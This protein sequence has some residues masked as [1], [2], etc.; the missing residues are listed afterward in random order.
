MPEQ[1][2]LPIFPTLSCPAENACMR[3][4]IFLVLIKRISFSFYLSVPTST[5]QLIH[6]GLTVPQPYDLGF[7]TRFCYLRSKLFLNRYTTYLRTIAVRERF[8]L[9]WIMCVSYARDYAI[10]LILRFSFSSN[11]TPLFGGQRF[12]R[13]D[14]NKQI[15][16]ARKVIRFSVCGPAFT[17]S[18]FG[19]LVLICLLV[20]FF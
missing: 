12:R 8:L 7:T 18:S 14:N 11:P 10:S 15:I 4:K 3:K 6:F 2:F 17:F 20:S 5:T 13:H 1:L 19:C 9:P 16:K